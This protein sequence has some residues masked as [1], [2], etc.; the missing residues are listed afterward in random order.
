[1]EN[2]LKKRWYTIKERLYL[3]AQYLCK[4]GFGIGQ[5]I[6]YTVDQVNKTVTVTVGRDSKRKVAQTTQRTGKKVPVIDIKGEEIRTFFARQ[7]KV[8]MEISKGKILFTVIEEA[9]T[10][11]KVVCLDEVRNQKTQAENNRF[12]ISVNEFAK[13]ANY[14]QLT[15]FDLFRTNQM[16]ID[17]S[18]T[19]GRPSLKEKAIKMLS[20]FSGS[21]CLD[22]GFKNEGYDIVF[23]NDRFDARTMRD[24]HIQTYRQNIGDHILMRDV[25]ALTEQDIPQVEFVA[26]G[27]PC[28]NFS[29]LNTKT[30]F[31]DSEEEHYP[32]VEKAIDIINWSKAKAFLIENVEDFISVKKGIF[33]KRF[34]ERLSNFNIIPRLIDATQLGSAQKRIRSFIL[35]ICGAQ[36]QI[37]LPFLF[38][39]RTVKQAFQNIEGAPQQDVFF[40]PT[41]LIL[42][43]MRH[44]PQ[45][46]CIKDVPIHLRSA[47]KKFTDYCMRLKE[48]GQANTVAHVQDHVIFHPTLERYISVRETARLFSLPDDFIFLGSRTAIF[49]MLKNAVDYRVSRFLAKTIKAQL[50]PLL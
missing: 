14:D 3:E 47:K 48:D 19:S 23:A 31:R 37:E 45:G 13:A 24:S 22:L 10:K 43:R 28:V 20:L 30:N 34:K 26:A 41:P 36:P 8:E 25:M 50:V 9:C 7:Q 17:Q 40:Q 12:S 27:I 16:E 32:L 49:E 29:R 38:E 33:V 21:G 6:Q 4:Y 39:N 2:A 18:S 5:P 42:E 11:S 46:G 44:V 15:I 35:G 1:M